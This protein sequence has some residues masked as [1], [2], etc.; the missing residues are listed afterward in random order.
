M[1]DHLLP[2]LLP[3]VLGS[4]DPRA[5]RSPSESHFLRPKLPY[6]PVSVC[7]MAIS[8]TCYWFNVD[9][10]LDV[11]RKSRSLK[12]K[13]TP[14]LWSGSYIACGRD[15]LFKWFVENIVV[16]SLLPAR[17]CILHRP[18]WWYCQVKVRQRQGQGLVIIGL[19]W[20]L[21]TRTLLKNNNKS[22]SE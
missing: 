13:L 18:K 22:Y 5:P 21:L 8:K 6:S 19:R 14:A 17:L 12:R 9:W 10:K 1:G 7:D 11:F 16:V 15:M 3:S 20:S 4:R 2:I